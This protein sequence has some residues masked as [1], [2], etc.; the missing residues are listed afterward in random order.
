[1]RLAEFSIV[2]LYLNLRSAEFPVGFSTTYIHLNQYSY[3]VFFVNYYHSIYHYDGTV[4][5]GFGS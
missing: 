2:I 5:R 4:V 3:Q 1:M